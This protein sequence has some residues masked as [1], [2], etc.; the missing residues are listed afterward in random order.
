MSPKEDIWAGAVRRSALAQDLEYQQDALTQKIIAPQPTPTPGQRLQQDLQHLKTKT[1]THLAPPS[2][3]GMRAMGK[4][5]LFLLFLL[6][7]LAGFFFFVG[8]FLTCYTIF[9]PRPV[10]S[11]GP[12]DA[13]SY[14][15]IPQ[16]LSALP[17]PTSGG[18]QTTY[19]GRQALLRGTSSADLLAQA[20]DRARYT[21]SVQTR[22]AVGRALNKVSQGLR[23]TL[24][25]YLGSSLEP[26]TTGLA[27]SAVEKALPINQNVPRQA[28]AKEAI[29]GTKNNVQEAAPSPGDLTKTPTSSSGYTILVQEFS[30]SEE[31]QALTDVL[32]AQGFGAYIATEQT[33][34]GRVRYVVKAGQFTSYKEAREAA[35]LLGKQSQR[36]TRVALLRPV[37]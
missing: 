23:T 6:F 18:N 10:F 26:L 4:F 37:M 28:G 13:H 31:S 15:Q 3:P 11:S 29:A 30:T 7:L 32:R 33:A 19:A 24:G 35:A 25:P 20:E 36:P 27:R 14:D 1:H 12:L 22:S 16:G 2:N 5:K 21:A 9:P 34:S 8:G 17:T